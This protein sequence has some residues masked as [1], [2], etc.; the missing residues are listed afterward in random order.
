MTNLFDNTAA[1]LGTANPTGP[2][3]AQAKARMAELGGGIP[4]GIGDGN[5]VAPVA[6]FLASDDARYVTGHILVVDGGATA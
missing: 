6:A 1:I 2:L 3:A 5:D 4:L